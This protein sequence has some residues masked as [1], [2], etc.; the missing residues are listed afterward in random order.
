MKIAVIGVGLIGGSM[1]LKLKKNGL[2]SFV[3]GID[4]NENHLQ[5]A[6]NLGIIDEAVTLGEG[7]KNADL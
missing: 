4:H 1:M 3:Y 6:K 7:L 5:E 2:A